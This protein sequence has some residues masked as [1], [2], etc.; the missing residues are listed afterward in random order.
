MGDDNIAD[1]DFFKLGKI[2]HKKQWLNKLSLESKSNSYKTAYHSSLCLDSSYT[3]K[4]IPQILVDPR[5]P[6]LK[7]THHPQCKQ[8]KQN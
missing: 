3:H 7:I 2:S 6:Y 4:R 5:N 1:T 8:V